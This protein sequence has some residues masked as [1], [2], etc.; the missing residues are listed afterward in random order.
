M[1]HSEERK[2]LFLLPLLASKVVEVFL[3]CFVLFLGVS[4]RRG[5]KI[6]LLVLCVPRVRIQSIHFSFVDCTGPHVALELTAV[7]EERGF[8]IMEVN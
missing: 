8:E 1:H 4:S 2:A 6:Q 3:F 7:G 5:P